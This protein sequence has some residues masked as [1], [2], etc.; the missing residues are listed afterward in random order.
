MGK[1]Q[2][3]RTTLAQAFEKAKRDNS[4]KQGSSDSAVSGETS[5][6]RQPKSVCA[7]QSKKLERNQQGVTGVSAKKGSKRDAALSSSGEKRKSKSGRRS[8]RQSSGRAHGK[9]VASRA[10][11]SDIFNDYGASQS[12]TGS[13]VETEPGRGGKQ[14]AETCPAVWKLDGA[15]EDVRVSEFFD[16][17][18]S[19]PSEPQILDDPM[20]WAKVS[21]QIRLSNP[22]I[23]R[24]GLDMGTSATKV[25]VLDPARDSSAWAIPFYSG[26][27][28]DF[29]LPTSLGWDGDQPFIS[30]HSDAIRP[31]KWRL[32]EGRLD[33]DTLIDAIAYLAIVLRHVVSWV[34]REH[35]NYYRPENLVWE[36]RVGL[37]AEST[38]N[39]RLCRIYQALLSSALEIAAAAGPIDR[40]EI[41]SLLDKA[42]QSIDGV[43]SIPVD[44]QFADTGFLLPEL[45]TTELAA[46]IEGFYRSRRWDADRPYGLLFDVGASTLDC[47]FCTFVADR[48][49]HNQLTIF[50]RC[51][52]PLGVFRLHEAR[53]EWL[54]SSLES[55]KVV[56]DG[57]IDA[58]LRDLLA[59]KFDQPLPENVDEYLEGI[60]IFGEEPDREFLRLISITV[61]KEILISGMKRFF[62]QIPSEQKI[63]VYVS[64]GGSRHSLYK[65]YLQRLSA[66][67]NATWS[68][69]IHSLGIPSFVAA[70][71]LSASQRDR[72]AV[73][74]G[75][76][77]EDDWL[78]NYPNE[79]ASYQVKRRDNSVTFISKDQV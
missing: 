15:P 39:E 58:L 17:S 27:D 61:V 60:E 56:P 68:A 40:R 47:A 37:P 74:Y 55:M 34:Y 44:A 29:L 73:A 3:P 75:L 63:P 14:G 43:A 35:G 21:A 67:R 48:P 8:R 65:S 42:K 72:L 33:G 5:L 7:E 2:K 23:L 19:E 31:F 11:I 10:S 38:S 28:N 30:G 32:I 12:P 41:N 46:N 62:G 71:G 78:V 22:K 66:P 76:C 9:G 77:A 52:A 53:V 57:R 6:S 26:A 51:V 18:G 25:I 70:P 50:T 20:G 59:I 1:S 64:G 69:E 45:P 36:L 4:A 24:L 79:I 49:R 13:R 16:N 54:L